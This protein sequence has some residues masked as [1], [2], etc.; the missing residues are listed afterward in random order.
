MAEGDS[1]VVTGS[2]N[3]MLD[4]VN[5]SLVFLVLCKNAGI[6]YEANF[7]FQCTKGEGRSM[8]ISSS[9][10]GRLWWWWRKC[11]PSLWGLGCL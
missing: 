2:M 10:E 7:K 9:R 8:A 11:V 3:F 4:E 6:L 1:N 5:G